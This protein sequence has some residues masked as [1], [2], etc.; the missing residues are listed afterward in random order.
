M[1]GRYG[2]FCG[3]FVGKDRRKKCREGNANGAET[4]QPRPS[5]GYHPLNGQ[6]GRKFRL[7][8]L[9]FSNDLARLTLR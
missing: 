7:G 4:R 1:I 5:H 9:L 6:K 3:F 2:P 8:V